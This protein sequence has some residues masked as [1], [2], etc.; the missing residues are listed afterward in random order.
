MTSEHRLAQAWRIAGPVQNVPNLPSAS[1]LC[2]AC[3]DACPVGIDIP[4]LLDVGRNFVT[5][6]LDISPAHREML[7]NNVHSITGIAKERLDRLGDTDRERGMAIQIHG[8]EGVADP[9]LST[10]MGTA[11]ALRLADGPDEVHM[12]QLGKLTARELNA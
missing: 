4:K 8:G 5:D 10:L 2:G 11:R 12:S 6:F 1:S 9:E 3:K 7:V